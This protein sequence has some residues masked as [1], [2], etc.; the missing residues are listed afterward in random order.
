MLIDT[1]YLYFRA[2]HGLPD[3]LRT[4][5]GEPV[6]AVRG[7][8]DF[9]AALIRD[10]RPADVVCCWDADWRPAWRVEL[11]PSYKAHRV[12]EAPPDAPEGGGGE[13]VPD[14]LGRQVPWIRA[15]LE[16]LGLPVV[17]VPGH[18]AD[19]VLATLAEHADAGAYVVTGDRDLLQLVDDDRGIQV[20]WVAGGVA[21]RQLVDAA[22][23]EAKHGVR[24][25]QYVA[26]AALR[27]DPSDG[28]PGVRGIGE[29]TAA[30]LLDRFGSLAGILRAAADPAEAGLTP[31]QRA[32]LV[33]GADYLTRAVPVI[34][35]V[36]DLPL[37]EIV[38]RPVDHAAFTALADHLGLGGSAKRILS[39]LAEVR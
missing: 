11:V 32:K 20:V 9:L 13:E 33:A 25:D 5:A 31:S 10:L 6:N 21:K 7:T 24:P 29:K 19:D 18:E 28:L 16:A 17:G 38:A 27:G 35:V 8:L 37:G 3:S 14:D 36:R 15:A 4:P 1:S 30:T 2:F 22:W 34:E 26:L 12:A 39:A 23:V